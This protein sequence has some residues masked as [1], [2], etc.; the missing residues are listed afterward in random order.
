MGFSR[1][2][3]LL[4]AALAL[5][6]TVQGQSTSSGSSSSS[7][8]SSSTSPSS[9]A[10]SGT[11]TS[12]SAAAPTY[13]AATGTAYSNAT[14]TQLAAYLPGYTYNLTE[15]SM[16]TRIGI[17]NQT[18]QFC[19]SAKCSSSAANVTSNF[20]NPD[21]MGWDCACNNGATSRLQ[22]LVV[23]VNTYDCRLRT[24]ACLQQC[25]NPN[26]SPSV[27]STSNCQA[28]CNYILG[29]TCG[30]S[31]QVIPMYQVSNYG[32]VPKYYV[33]TSKGGVAAGI[34]TSLAVGMAAP[35]LSVV[36]GTFGAGYWVLVR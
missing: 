36:L 14:A 18:T 21:T 22:P 23:P 2:F 34:T 10:S 13:S 5:A 31:A 32:D 17:C 15:E 16:T 29:S 28:A 7:S 20:C 8:A 35:W 11:P 26:A 24:S 33:D 27:N 12:S 1:P 6:T 4:A 9:V 25:Q 30:T 19:A 3:H